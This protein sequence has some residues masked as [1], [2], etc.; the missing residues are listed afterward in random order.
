MEC[1]PLPESGRHILEISLGLTILVVGIWVAAHI[2]R[3]SPLTKRASFDDRRCF[4]PLLAAR[5][6]L[7]VVGFTE[8]TRRVASQCVRVCTRQQKGWWSTCHNVYEGSFRCG[9]RCVKGGTGYTLR[10]DVTSAW[11]CRVM[12]CACTTTWYHGGVNVGQHVAVHG[13]AVPGFC[14]VVFQSRCTKAVLYD[15]V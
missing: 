2:T 7:H 14:V 10:G 3:L 11:C 1:Q 5:G 4:D 9:H 6:V 13:L 15:R 12:A 8:G